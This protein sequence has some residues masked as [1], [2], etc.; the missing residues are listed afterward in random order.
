M[1]AS[2]SCYLSKCCHNCGLEQRAPEAS[3][4][5]LLSPDHLL[6]YFSDLLPHQHFNNKVTNDILRLLSP[7][8]GHVGAHSAPHTMLL[9]AHFLTVCG[10]ENYSNVQT[11]GW[12]KAFKVLHIIYHLP[13]IYTCL[14]FPIPPPALPGCSSALYSKGLYLQPC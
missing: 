7:D 6:A 4:N 3:H 8:T 12:F 5:G 1:K 2:F 13:V 9:T 11:A 10:I 14:M